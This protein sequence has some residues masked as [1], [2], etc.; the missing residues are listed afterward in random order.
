MEQQFPEIV[1]VEFTANMERQLD[2]VESGKTDWIKTLDA[3]L[4]GVCANA[5]KGGGEPVRRAHRDP[6]CRKSD[7]VCELCGRKMVIKSGRYGKFLACPGY[8]E[9]K[10]PSALWRTRARPVPNAAGPS[11]RKI[12]E[13]P[14]ILRLFPVSEFRFCLLERALSG[15][16]SPLR[17][18]ALKKKGENAGLYCL[19]EG[20]GYETGAPDKPDKPDKAAALRKR[21][22]RM[23]GAAH[24]HRRG[25]WRA[26]RPPGRRPTPTCRSR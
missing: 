1:D 3:F 18:N 14:E 4:S 22:G 2:S 10:T 6:P 7:V 8:P 17:K 5:A 13:G 24:R 19:T 25:A 21:E 15:A 9:C 16:L 23:S 12:Q 11:W 20:C 26:A